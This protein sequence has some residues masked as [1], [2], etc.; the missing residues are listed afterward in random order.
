MSPSFILAAEHGVPTLQMQGWGHGPE[1]GGASAF[2]G[3][4]RPPAGETA[5]RDKDSQ[6]TEG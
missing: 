5:P 3:S 6:E 2:I 4:P 1:V